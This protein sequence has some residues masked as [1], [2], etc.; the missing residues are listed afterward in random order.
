MSR[1]TDQL[2]KNVEIN[3]ARSIRSWQ[4]EN[5]TTAP[6]KVKDEFRRGFEKSA[7]EVEGQLPHVWNAKEDNTPD[8]FRRPGLGFFGG[9]SFDKEGKIVR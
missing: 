1:K 5:K 8:D 7:A 4:K 3:T 9:V 2:K 6:K